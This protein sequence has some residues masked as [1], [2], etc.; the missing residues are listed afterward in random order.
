MRLRGQKG[1]KP[2]EGGG[3]VE[4]GSGSPV[5]RAKLKPQL[6]CSSDAL[7]IQ[8]SEYMSEKLLAALPG[9]R[10]PKRTFDSTH[11]K[12]LGNQHDRLDDAWMAR[13]FP[14]KD[15]EKRAKWLDKLQKNVKPAT[16]R[17]LVTLG[18]QAWKE[19]GPPPPP[20]GCLAYR[21][22]RLHSLP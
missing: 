1:T 8:T 6:S 11:S 15:F 9:H 14:S 16:L 22:A 3:K 19:I 17:G 10:Q 2:P 20:S 4:D 5:A 21:H 7:N 13:L 12:D 18:E